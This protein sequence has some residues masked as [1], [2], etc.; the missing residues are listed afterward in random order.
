[1]HI[2]S[3]KVVKVS[4]FVL[5][6]MSLYYFDP[7][8]FI[9]SVLLG[10]LLYGIVAG[11]IL[12]RG[13]SH[14]SFKFK[15]RFIEYLSCLLLVISGQGSPIGWVAI[16]RLHHISTDK[17]GDPQSPHVIGRLRTLLSWYDISKVNLRLVKDLLRI[18]SIV[19]VHHH[20]GKLYLVY[21]SIFMLIDPVMTM[22][23][24]GMSVTICALLVGIFNTV[25]HGKRL[26]SDGHYARNLPLD[27]FFFGE[28]NHYNHHNNP[29]A[30][31]LSKYDLCYFIICMLGTISVSR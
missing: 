7:F 22:Y 14:S 23:Y 11:A 27:L 1:M 8:L 3:T 10:W 9:T 29:T 17:D 25:A 13:L 28:A 20:Y 26:N 31:R 30:V 5:T 2:N 21:A 15:N 16:H 18:P 24:A 12:H 4:S 6:I 19:F